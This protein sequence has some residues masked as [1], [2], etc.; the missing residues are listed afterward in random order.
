MAENNGPKIAT[1][2]FRH[3]DNSTNFVTIGDSIGRQTEIYRLV[4]EGNVLQIRHG[5][6]VAA[7]NTAVE[8]ENKRS[9]QMLARLPKIFVAMF[10]VFFETFNQTAKK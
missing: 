4:T 2:S 3:L 10:M 9:V 6:I 1:L 7:V 8:H 5:T